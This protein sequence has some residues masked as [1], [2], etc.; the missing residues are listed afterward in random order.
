MRIATNNTAKG[1]LRGSIGLINMAAPARPRRIARVHRFNLNAVFAPDVTDFGEQRRERPAVVNQP[2]F[3]RHPDPRSD[4]L[5]AAFVPCGLKIA[6]L[7]ESSLSNVFDAAAFEN[8]SSVDRG[9]SDDAGVDADY[10]LAFRIG[11]LSRRDHV[12]VPY[13]AFA[14]YVGRRLDLPGSIEVLPVIVGENQT[15]SDSAI[16]RR[17]RGVFLI[18]FH[19]QGPRGV[20]NCGGVFPAVMLFFVSLIGF[21]NY[22][23]GRANEIG[24][25]LRQ[26]A[27]ILISDMVKGHRVKDFLLK[28][29]FGSVIERDY[30]SFLRLG[31]RARILL[32]HLKLYLQRD[33]HL[34]TGVLYYLSC[35]HCKRGL[36]SAKPTRNADF[37][38]QL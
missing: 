14:G 28:S 12:Q 16:K 21:R 38:C 8:L 22:V 32:S 4:A 30:I 24:R 35:W 13:P 15:D 1:R 31:K 33:S 11:N 36:R 34:H 9:D 29:D 7:F 37:L 2:L 23:A 20:A 3:L 5:I 25:K 27:H 10:L 26:F 18:K 19:R 17:Q 6:A